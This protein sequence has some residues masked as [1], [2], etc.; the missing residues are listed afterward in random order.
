MLGVQSH[1][2]EAELRAAGWTTDVTFQVKISVCVCVCVSVCGVHAY[3]VCCAE[4]EREGERER[5]RENRHSL[6]VCVLRTSVCVCVL[7]V[8]CHLYLGDLNSKVPLASSILPF[9]S[10]VVILLQNLVH[11]VVVR[12]LAQILGSMVSLLYFRS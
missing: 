3:S 6:V 10:P 2:V 12:I 5:G 1:V 7:N 8:I 9:K 11:A 4:K